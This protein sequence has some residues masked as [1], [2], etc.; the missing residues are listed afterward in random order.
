MND[1]YKKAHDAVYGQAN[2]ARTREK[3]L[4]DDNE[5]KIIE[6]FIRRRKSKNTEKGDLRENANRR[7]DLQSKEYLEVGSED[8]AFYVET[9]KEDIENIDLSFLDYA[10]ST[11]SYRE[12]Q[13]KIREDADKINSQYNKMLLG[14]CTA[15]LLK[16]VNKKTI[17]TSVG[18]Y[19]G[20]CL[21]SKSFAKASTQAVQNVMYPYVSKKADEYGPNSKW[22][23]RRDK[24]LA[25]QN[26]GRLPLTPKSAAIQKLAFDKQY[27][28]DIRDP[29]NKNNL[30][31]LD[32]IYNDAVLTLEEQCEVD[33]LSLAEVRGAERTMLK[34]M[35]THDPDFLH[36]Y[37]F[38][39]SK[40]VK[41]G[42]FEKNEKGD[43]VW[44]GKYEIN[45]DMFE[46][47]GIHKG[48]DFELRLKP[49]AMRSKDEHLTAMSG[50]YNI[51]YDKCDSYEDFR[52]LQKNEEFLELQATLTGALVDDCVDKKVLDIIKDAENT[53]EFKVN[54][55]KWKDTLS[56]DVKSKMGL[57]GNK[58]SF[59]EIE[60]DMIE[61]Q[62]GA[63][64]NWLTNHMEFY[65]DYCEEHGYPEP[66]EEKSDRGKV[67][68]LT[69]SEHCSGLGNYVENDYNK[70]DIIYADYKEL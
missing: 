11:T 54:L 2:Y 29:K 8:E 28:E 14:A 17:L 60:N 59:E 40:D 35:A 1:E 22:G 70:D 4:A 69:L 16:G 30:E 5:L 45:T 47:M 31:E 19:A 66:E 7:K 42:S 56:N 50:F 33:G 6:D 55:A 39:S 44:F 38:L 57:S 46:S 49:R 3:V 12:S 27:Y 58:Y 32:S 34:Q 53:D 15:P 10:S 51:C 65:G 48:D 43:S 9:L 21:V 62:K 64:L 26:G 68:M 24:I 18:M 37:G 13:K 61:V 36:K 52:E 25:S 41:Q 67:A 20:M 63:E 23:K